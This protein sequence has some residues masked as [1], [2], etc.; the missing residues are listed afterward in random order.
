MV[1]RA[2]EADS[3]ENRVA[4]ENKGRAM[5]QPRSMSAATL[6]GGRWDSEAAKK[7]ELHSL[8]TKQRRRNS[9]SDASQ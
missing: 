9:C 7:E 2:T 1:C 8:C 6:L 5:V 4:L 3:E